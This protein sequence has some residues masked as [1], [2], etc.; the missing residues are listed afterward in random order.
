MGRN[1]RVGLLGK[2]I[3]IICFLFSVV[4]C[5]LIPQSLSTPI[6][7]DTE[8][9][10][11]TSQKRT[12]TAPTLTSGP[13]TFT[14]SQQ[15]IDFVSSA[16]APDYV[17]EVVIVRIENAYC[18]YRPDVNGA[19]TFCNDQPFPDHNF[20]LIAWGKDWTDLDGKCVFVE[21]EVEEYKGK[22]EI[23]ADSRDQVT[24]CD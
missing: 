11:S 1:I 10:T 8:T 6:L 5:E 16:D 22:T 3:I 4:A 18:S 12:T 15:F 19:P 7:T 21:G 23:I 14:P 2:E 9:P 24:L 20:T 13:P 17:G